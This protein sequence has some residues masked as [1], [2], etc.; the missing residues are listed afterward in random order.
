VQNRWRTVGGSNAQPLFY[1]SRPRTV[2]SVTVTL[3][4]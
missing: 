1:Q 2:K 4:L 3:L